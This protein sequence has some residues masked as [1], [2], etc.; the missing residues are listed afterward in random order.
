MV[1][2]SKS[3]S[4]QAL[5]I[6]RSN[7]GETDRIVTLL[8]REQGKIAVVAKGVRQLKSSKRAYLE[9][10]SYINCLLII[11]KSL[12]ILTQAT[13][14]NDA[15]L[16]R[17][18]LQHLRQLL[19]LLE[20]IDALFVES[21]NEEML[22]NDVMDLRNRILKKNISNDEIRQ[23]LSTLIS[24]L[25]Y[26]AFSETQYQTVGEY[27]AALSDKPLRSWDYLKVGE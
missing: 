5:V 23:K 17:D 14:I 24:Q 20:I 8:T 3:L 26:Q 22:F 2:Q 1:L 11:T 16:V 19:Q 12:P 18:S 4:T 27:V 7:V 25:G 6:K 15:N 13:L 9:P 21:Q 10:G